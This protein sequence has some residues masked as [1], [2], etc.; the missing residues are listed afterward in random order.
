[1]IL[2]KVGTK[3]LPVKYTFGNIKKFRFKNVEELQ[4][5]DPS[6]IAEHVSSLFACGLNGLG[7]YNEEEVDGLIDTY[8]EE[9]G[10]L[11]ELAELLNAEYMKALGLKI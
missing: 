10:S 7:K 6:I 8:L 4:S 1:M 2:I 5:G 3:E 9:G 11:T